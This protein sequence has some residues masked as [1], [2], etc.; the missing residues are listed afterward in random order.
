[1][2]NGSAHAIGPDEDPAAAICIDFLDPL[3]G[4]TSQIDDI[5]QGIS[6]TRAERIAALWELRSA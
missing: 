6:D 1:V 5:L 4:L 3:M 2:T